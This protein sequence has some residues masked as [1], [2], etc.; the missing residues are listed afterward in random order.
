MNFEKYTVKSQEALQKAAE[1]ATGTGRSLIET[2]HLLKGLMSV[3]ENIISFLFKKLNIQKIQLEEK[4]DQVLESY[5]KA[6]GQQPYLS[7][8]TAGTL[9]KCADS[10]PQLAV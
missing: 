5:P 4:V 7:N 9:Q 8:E 1:I 6:S 10:C 2:G 3:D